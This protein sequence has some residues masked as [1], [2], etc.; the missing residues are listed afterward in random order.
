[1]A[2]EH[3]LRLR[4]DDAV[5]RRR[6]GGVV[7]LL[8]QQ[9]RLLALVG[10]PV[11]APQGPAALQLLAVEAELQL[12][13]PV[14]RLRVADRFPGAAVPDD[15]V[16]GAVLARGNRALAPRVIERMVLDVHRHP[17]VGRVEARAL[18]HRPALQRALELEPEVVVQTAGGVL[19][20]HERERWADARLAALRL[21]GDAEVALL[22]VGRERFHGRVAATVVPRAPGRGATMAATPRRRCPFL[23]ARRP[24]T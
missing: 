19:L 15:D 1:L 16:A 3:A 20:D 17:L 24:M 22:E 13:G 10:V 2:G 12:A 4:V 21:A 9:P 14:T 18:G 23:R 6:S 7:A 11:H 5:L 8:D